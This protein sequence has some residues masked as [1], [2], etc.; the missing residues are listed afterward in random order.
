MMKG[1]ASAGMESETRSELRDERRRGHS[2]WFHFVA[3]DAT[4][5]PSH[6]RQ[7]VLLQTPPS[8]LRKIVAD[9]RLAVSPP[10]LNEIDNVIDILI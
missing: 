9:T 6:H 3:E 1:M 4:A 5:R 10:K 8:R 7:A 2:L